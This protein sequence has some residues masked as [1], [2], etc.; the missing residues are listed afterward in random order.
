M[1]NMA[2]IMKG[3]TTDSKVLDEKQ[4][5]KNIECFKQVCSMS[6]FGESKNL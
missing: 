2:Q 3:H 6:D 5:M 4:W 1:M